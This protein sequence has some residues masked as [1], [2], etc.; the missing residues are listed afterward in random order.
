MAVDVSAEVRE[1][2]AAAQAELRAAAGRADVRWADVMQLH[3]TLQFLGNVPDERVQ[4]IV[5]AIARASAGTGS[6]ALEARGLGGFPSTR[7]PRVVWAGVGG[8]VARLARLAA[9]IGAALGP[10]GYPAE[11]RA[12]HAHVTLGRVRS[13]RGLGR[14][15]RGIEAAA[16]EPLGAWTA[17]EVVLYQSRLRPTGALYEAVAR[18]PLRPASRT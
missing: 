18:L 1:A 13:P 10:C 8:D 3:L 7:R 6:L 15:V 9:S 17:T 12:F 16:D 14:L 11:A 4:D 5:D 2:V